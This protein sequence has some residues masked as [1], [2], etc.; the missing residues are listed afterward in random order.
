MLHEPLTVKALQYH[1]V[2]KKFGCVG[3]ILLVIQWLKK[4]LLYAGS[5]DGTATVTANDTTL[6]YR[7]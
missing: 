5:L 7:A 6:R 4:A 3:K 2:W 1:Y